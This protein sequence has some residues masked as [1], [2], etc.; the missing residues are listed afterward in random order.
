[1]L[2]RVPR[3]NDVSVE[4]KHEAFF[5]T[6]DE[7]AIY[8]V[9]TANFAAHTRLLRVMRGAPPLIAL[10]LNGLALLCSDFSSQLADDNDDPAA[11]VA[12]RDDFPQVCRLWN[13]NGV[14]GGIYALLVS[15]RVLMDITMRW[16]ALVSQWRENERRLMTIAGEEDTIEDHSA[17]QQ[18]QLVTI[19]KH[20]KIQ[21]ELSSWRNKLSSAL[22]LVAQCLS[23]GAGFDALFVLMS[24]GGVMQS[25]FAED[26]RHKTPVWYAF[27]M[28]G[29]RLK[30]NTAV[31]CMNASS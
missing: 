10:V 22:T 20:D 24:L 25:S 4:A 23:E 12:A 2:R 15:A 19:D 28:L 18:S 29:E 11:F 14:F 6:L 17:A 16:P 7:F 3:G 1:V 26:W 8:E 30:C 5:R 31:A 27:L 9:A 13:A 21:A